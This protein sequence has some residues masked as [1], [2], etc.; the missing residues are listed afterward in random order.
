MVKWHQNL[1]KYRAHIQDILLLFTFIMTEDLMT[2]NGAKWDSVQL[3]N[4]S[5]KTIFA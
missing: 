3:Q 2:K 5:A 1:S 4:A